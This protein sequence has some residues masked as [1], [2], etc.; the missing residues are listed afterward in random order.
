M[1]SITFAIN[2]NFAVPI[3][4]VQLALE[5]QRSLYLLR[6]LHIRSSNEPSNDFRAIQCDGFNWVKISAFYSLGCAVGLNTTT[7]ISGI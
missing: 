6:S 1:T 5:S 3:A 7:P 2:D 4:H